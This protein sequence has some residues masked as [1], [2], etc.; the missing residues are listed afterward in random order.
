MKSADVS[1]KIG[2]WTIAL[3]LFL[4][5][6]FFLPIT[7]DFYDFNKM[8]LLFVSTG[9][10]LISMSV[11][12][13]L[14]RQVR[15]NRSPFVIPFLLL[16]GSWLLST[17]LRS[18]NYMDS[19]FEPGQT[20]TIVALILFFFASVNLI[21]TRKEIE[22]LVTVFISSLSLLALVTILWSSG[23]LSSAVPVAFMKSS[24]W[25][26]TGNP[27]SALVLLVSLI[28]FLAVLILK[29]KAG[30]LR[31]LLFS[32]ALFFSVIASGLVAYQL[33]KPASPF[34]PVFLPQSAA[35]SI[36]L[37][38]L[39]VSPLLGTGPSTYISDFTQYRPLS[40][41]MTSAWAFRFS[42]SNNYY[43][44]LLATGGIV[45][46][47]AYLFLVSRTF[48]VFSKALR[49]SS[50]SPLMPIVT[51][52]SASAL[53]IFIS[54]LIVAPSFVTLFAIVA[55]LS[56]TV[57]AL[58]LA[59]SSQVFDSNIDIIAASDS[60][61]RTPIL[62]WVS[63]LISL[64]LFAPTMFTSFKVFMAEIYYQKA[65]V[66][67][68]ANQGKVTYDSLIQA[69]TYNP[70]R[71]IYRVV[72]SQTNLLL[73]N[74]LASKTDIS[75]SDKTTIT[76][77]IQQAIREGKNAVTLNPGKVTNVE[78][79]A[80]IYR[81]LINLAQG[82]DSWTVAAYQEAIKLDPSNPNLRIALGGVLYAQKGYSQAAGL[83]Q[84]AASLKP[85]MPNAYYNLAAAYREMGDYQNAYLAMQTVLSYL[86]RNSADYAKAQ[87]ELNDLAKKLPAAP[88]PTPTPEAAAP[89]QSQLQAPKPLP[90]AKITPIKLPADMAPNATPA[91]T[92]APTAKPTPQ[93]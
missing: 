7:S 89:V 18:P 25:S 73:A 59:G 8:M 30:S 93:P 74:S 53:L 15:L 80:S 39:K 92:A 4:S 1:Q 64:A 78:N 69:I 56:V 85:D 83:F 40:L 60:G 46:L 51:A 57:V 23:L 33:F 55:L 72:Y 61:I 48:G 68:A 49:S 71:D 38:T 84:T 6:L 27:L 67:A 76:T 82:A 32:V 2:F 31:T 37:E 42:S 19:F 63:L 29:D 12:F 36:A 10:L 77:L 79:L 3:T 86:D 91:P 75:D 43:L 45:G 11:T 44:Q 16:G 58:K 5:P 17:F 52:A 26:P 62:P 41:N 28:P 14:D 34:K 9:I 87:G 66:G 47:I 50:E 20:G 88:T 54:Q 90:T 35:W 81:T 24:V 65:L 70:Y 21:R 22:T 13:I